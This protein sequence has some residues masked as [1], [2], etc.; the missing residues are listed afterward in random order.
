MKEVDSGFSPSFDLFAVRNK[1]K[2][3][4]QIVEDTA[5]ELAGNADTGLVTNLFLYAAEL[6][7]IVEKRIA[8]IEYEPG[9]TDQDP[10]HRLGG[11]ILQF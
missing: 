6:E 5:Y 7:R 9:N 1:L 8:P 10:N 4:A 2:M 11:N 3:A